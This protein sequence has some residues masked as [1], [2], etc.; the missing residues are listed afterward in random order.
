MNQKNKISNKLIILFIFLI[1][2]IIIYKLFFSHPNQKEQN[3]LNYSKNEKQEQVK[4]AENEEPS[5]LNTFS[6]ESVLMSDG[7]HLKEAPDTVNQ[8]DTESNKFDYDAYKLINY[9]DFLQM[10]SDHFDEKKSMNFKGV[11]VFNSAY[12]FQITIPNK[13]IHV[14]NELLSILD[15]ATMNK[16]ISKIFTHYFKIN[17]QETSIYFFIQNKLATDILEKWEKNQ[18]YDFYVF[19]PF[20]NHYSNYVPLL[21]NA[22]NS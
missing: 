21:V 15:S 7:S 12:K 2:I 5:V 16:E 9:N 8:N 13:P 19:M 18:T 6:D 20:T 17:Q 3:E 22:T 11:S 4:P 10:I 14:S 1:F